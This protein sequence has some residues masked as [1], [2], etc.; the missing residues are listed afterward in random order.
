MSGALVDDLSTLIG[1]LNELDRNGE[2]PRHER[3]VPSVL[4]VDDAPAM[5][6]SLCDVLR[7][8]GYPARSARDGREA[9]AQLREQAFDLM[10]LDLVMPDIDGLEVIDAARREGYETRIVVVSGEPSFEYV[11]QALTR[12]AVDFIRKPCEPD[13]LLATLEKTA[14]ELMLARHSRRMA[15][16]LRNSERLHRFLVDASPDIV[17]MLDTEGCFVFV[18]QRVEALFGFAR[19]EL[20]GRHYSVFFDEQDLERARWVFNERRTGGRASRNVELRLRRPAARHAQREQ[21]YVEVTAMGVYADPEHPSSANFLGTYGIARDVTEH[22]RAQQL[23]QFQAYHDLLTHLPNRALLKDR[24]EVALAQARRKRR[25]LALM[26][27]DLDRFKVVNDTLG[28]SVGDRLL[29]AVATRLQGCIRS[30]DTLARF[31]GDEFTLLLPEIHTVDDVIATARKTLSK[32]A[33]PFFVDDHEFFVGASIGIAMY[34]DAG[35][36]AETLIRNADVAM[37]HIKG[38][39]KNSYQFFTPR[40]NERYSGQLA[41]DRELRGALERGELIAYYQPQVELTSG[42]VVGVEALARWQHPQRGLVSPSEFIPLAEETGLISAVDEQIQR[43]ACAEVARLNCESDGQVQLSLNVSASQLEQE[44]FVD[45]LLE[46]I[47]ATGI[48]CNAVRLEITESVIMREMEVI[49]PKLTA[50]AE[51]G[52]RI[53][54]DDFGVGY[55]SLSYLQRFPVDTLKIDRSFINELRAEA[56]SSSIV[57]AIIHMAR[58]LGLDVIAEG[59]EHPEQLA[60]LT[61]QGCQRVQGF[62]FSEPLPPEALQSLLERDAA[63]RFAAR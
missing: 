32:F 56:A 7:S 4:V 58:G 13:E 24:L 20:I 40:M 45:W 25:R 29:Q 30:G 54:I 8:A 59:V 36:D 17:Y 10:L 21:G 38:R 14:R 27:L 19:S 2:A 52:V 60:Y 22:K 11:Q 43:L 31:G 23:I 15:E 3:D 12:G 46:T 62:I 6:E 41:L 51:Q 49:V 26:F 50:L 16:R 47:D 34:P 39:G 61:A 28:H 9:L 33:A 44:H 42:R 57:N 63:R 53:G 37:Y 55:S 18:N 35:E 48:R 5:R 1:E